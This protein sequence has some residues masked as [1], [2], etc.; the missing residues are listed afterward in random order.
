LARI[1]T[2]QEEVE[3]TYRRALEELDRQREDLAEEFL[4]RQ[5]R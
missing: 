2:L 5:Q 1:H 4:R 3:E